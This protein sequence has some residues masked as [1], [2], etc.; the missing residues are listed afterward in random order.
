[1][2]LYIKYYDDTIDLIYTDNTWKCHSSHIL[3]N[4]IYDGEVQ[5]AN[6]II[7]NW[8]NND[9]NEKDWFECNEVIEPFQEKLVHFLLL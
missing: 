7:K 9:C 5:N 1:M 8:N 6:L 3:I 2:E 4:N